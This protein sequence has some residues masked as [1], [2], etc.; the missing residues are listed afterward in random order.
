MLNYQTDSRCHDNGIPHGKE[1]KKKYKS[2]FLT[3]LMFTNEIEKKNQI[4]KGKK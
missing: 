1:L 4:K 3:N 2:Q